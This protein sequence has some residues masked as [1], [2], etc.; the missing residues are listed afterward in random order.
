MYSYAVFGAQKSDFFKKFV[1]TFFIGR[2]FILRNLSIRNEI[3]DHLEM[4]L[5]FQNHLEF[6]F[7]RKS[8]TFEILLP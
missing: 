7:N 6:K 2:T 8:K 5:K 3:C 4:F 1:L